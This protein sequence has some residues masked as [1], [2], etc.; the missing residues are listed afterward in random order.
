MV[1]VEIVGSGNGQDVIFRMP[2]GMEDFFVEV[3]AIDGNLVLFPFVRHANFARFENLARTHVLSR[4][5]EGS[6]P[7]GGAT[8]EHPEEV[9]VT[10]GHNLSVITFPS[11]FKLVENTERRENQR[12]NLFFGA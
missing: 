6:V 10:S 3:E 1:Q 9:V 4:R 8:I 12:V 7:L 11:A 2:R 5:L